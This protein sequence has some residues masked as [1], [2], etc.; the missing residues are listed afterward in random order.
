MTRKA[1]WFLILALA[2]GTSIA[3]TTPARA[4]EVDPPATAAAANTLDELFNALGVPFTN[5]GDNWYKAVW[6]DDNGR[7]VNMLFNARSLGTLGDGSTLTSVIMY[8][9]VT[10]VPAGFTPSP[11]LLKKIT[12]INTDL[13]M[14]SVVYVEEAKGFFYQSAFW[15]NDATTKTLNYQMLFGSF[16]VPQ[17]EQAL[18]PFIQG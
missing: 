10:S 9:S 6:T 2:T 12:D 5:S 4:P 1:R 15:L 3:A 17:I 8:V 13:A 11:A 16:I 18:R 14:G 7:S